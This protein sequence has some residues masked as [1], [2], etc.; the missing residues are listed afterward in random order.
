MDIGSCNDTRI[1]IKHNKQA[2]LFSEHSECQAGVNNL[3]K[4][5]TL[6]NQPSVTM[7]EK[8][9][10]YYVYLPLIA[11]QAVEEFI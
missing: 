2:K 8:D 5:Y 6:L 11:K 3:V 4:K 1:C 10:E 9:N 7:D